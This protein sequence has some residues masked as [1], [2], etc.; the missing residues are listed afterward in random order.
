N[1]VPHGVIVPEKPD[2]LRRDLIYAKASGFNM[3]RFIAGVGM[4]EQFDLCD[5]LGLMVY[6]ESIAAWKLGD[7]PKLAERF[8]RNNDDMI[9]RDRN[10][11]CITIW[12]L[13]NET[14]DSPTFRHA[15]AYLPKLRA[16]DPSRLVLL[17]SGRFDAE[18]LVGS[19][20]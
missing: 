10:H 1:H 20:S 6:E 11:A 8:D 9:R 4:P 15:V 13:L 17:N 3:V 12:G 19:I 2:F 7:S 5:E 16:L 18:P 14:D